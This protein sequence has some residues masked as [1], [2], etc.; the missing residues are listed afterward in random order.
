MLNFFWLNSSE[1]TYIRERSEREIG[2]LRMMKPPKN[3]LSSDLWEK[4]NHHCAHLDSRHT[5]ILASEASA[6]IFS[7]MMGLKLKLYICANSANILGGGSKHSLCPQHLGGCDSHRSIASVKS[8]PYLDNQ[9]AILGT[10]YLQ[11][12][13]GGYFWCLPLARAENVPPG[14]KKTEQWTSCP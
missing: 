8:A 5:L 2:Y 10:A 14:P 6:K 4:Q 7:G 11:G 3:F 1:P 12:D 9:G 13:S